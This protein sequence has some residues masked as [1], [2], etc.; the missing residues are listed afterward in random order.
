MAKGIFITGTGTDVGKTYIAAALCKL[1]QGYGHRSAYFKAAMSGGKKQD[2]TPFAAD[3]FYVKEKAGLTQSLESMCPYVFAEAL[4]P[5]LAARR[6]GV[7]IEENCIIEAFEALFAYDTITI[8]GAGSAL[9]P[10]YLE[11]KRPLW[12]LDLAKAYHVPAVVIS[13]AGLG[14]IGSL[15]MTLSYLQ[16]EQIEVRGVIVNGYDKRDFLHQDNVRVFHKT[17][18][19]QTIY[20]VEKGEKLHLSLEALEQLYRELS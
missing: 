2:G 3:A 18:G 13:S 4:S 1:W 17:F 14:S 5:H 9:C 19:I 11:N 8:E 20:T 16:T 15:G 6:A 7:A 12:F 10:L